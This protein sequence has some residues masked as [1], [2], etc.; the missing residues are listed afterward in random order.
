MLYIA[1]LTRCM[2]A[3]PCYREGA[4][5]PDYDIH[6]NTMF[7]AVKGHLALLNITLLNVSSY[8]S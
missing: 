5:I 2:S 4:P 8:S 3:G 7:V 6:H 1:N